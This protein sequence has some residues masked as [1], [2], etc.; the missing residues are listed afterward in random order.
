MFYFCQCVKLKKSGKTGK[1]STF[2]AHQ[3]FKRYM[4]VVLHECQRVMTAVFDSI[5][6]K[7]T[8][9]KI[10]L[11]FHSVQKTVW[12]VLLAVQVKVVRVEK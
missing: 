11:I 5:N 1:E 4:K 10:R 3:T 7:R 6:Q 8:I 12:P 2:S 9:Y